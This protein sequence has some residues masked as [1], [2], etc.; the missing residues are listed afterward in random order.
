MIGTHVGSLGGYWF[1]ESWDRALCQMDQG[2]LCVKSSDHK[3]SARI[4]DNA[5]EEVSGLGG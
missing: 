4:C 3:K 2:V 1:R 5:R